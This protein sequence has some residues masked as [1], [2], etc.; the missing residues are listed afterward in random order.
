MIHEYASNKGTSD[1]HAANS[2]PAPPETASA[3]QSQLRPRLENISAVSLFRQP[4]TVEDSLT[5]TEPLLQ[6]RPLLCCREESRITPASCPQ[7][8]PLSRVSSSY[9]RLETN[10][11]FQDTTFTGL[12]RRRRDIIT[13]VTSSG[14]LTTRGFSVGVH[15]AR[16]A[17]LTDCDV[18]KTTIICYT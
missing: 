3:L 8:R 4:A 10:G 16:S 13:A 11:S 5:C 12:L 6:G 7:R 15:R 17:S 2:E 18:L 1:L 14:K 9:T